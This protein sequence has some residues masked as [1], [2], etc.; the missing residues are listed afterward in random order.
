MAQSLIAAIHTQFGRNFASSLGAHIFSGE[1]HEVGRPIIRIDRR[2][3][4]VT[5]GV[6]ARQ[7]RQ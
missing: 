1:D 7:T 2:R 4:A 3:G 6:C 5:A